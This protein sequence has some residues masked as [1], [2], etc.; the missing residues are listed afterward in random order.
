MQIFY[1]NLHERFRDFCN[2]NTIATKLYKLRLTFIHFNLQSVLN[3]FHRPYTVTEVLR[4]HR[5]L[6]NSEDMFCFDLCLTSYS[7]LSF[8]VLFTFKL[9]GTGT[10]CECSSFSANSS[11]FK[12]INFFHLI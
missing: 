4:G 1:L 6:R 5:L 11:S 2:E 3:L 9:L 12:E 10:K 7:H 8:N